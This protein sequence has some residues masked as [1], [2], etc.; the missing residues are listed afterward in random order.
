MIELVDS[1]PSLRRQPRPL[2]PAAHR[3]ADVERVAPVGR[4]RVVR[5]ATR[6][7]RRGRCC[8]ATPGNERPTLAC[9]PKPA[10][11]SAPG[12]ASASEYH[13]R[14]GHQIRADAS[15]IS[16]IRERSEGTI[17][18]TNRRDNRSKKSRNWPIPRAKRTKRAQNVKHVHSAEPCTPPP[19]S[20]CACPCLRPRQ[21][22]LPPLPQKKILAAAQRDRRFAFAYHSTPSYAAR[23]HRLAPLPPP[24]ALRA[25]LA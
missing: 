22:P 11:A 13:S 9:S 12:P 20:P 19:V 10:P 1:D 23:R 6:R 21:R 3:A 18:F 25:A 4:G 7:W 15:S 17:H 8:V 5:V 16:Y 24:A 2:L 14:A